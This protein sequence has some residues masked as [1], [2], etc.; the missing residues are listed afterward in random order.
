MLEAPSGRDEWLP[1]LPCVTNPVKAAPR[2]LEEAGRRKE[3][4]VAA[5]EVL[6]AAVRQVTGR[7]PVDGDFDGKVVSSV[8]E[9]TRGLRVREL[10]GIV[11]ADYAD[12]ERGHAGSLARGRWA[13][14]ALLV[15]GSLLAFADNYGV[16][17]V[18]V[19]AALL[20]VEEHDDEADAE[21]PVP[22]QPENS[23]A[24]V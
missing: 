9:C 19:E 6:R 3:A 8:S 1:A 21:E 17:H 15:M 10:L 4:I 22:D 12:A 24:Q 14:K 2:I 11:V 16:G 13:V 5:E 7:D 20:L 18:V 23:L